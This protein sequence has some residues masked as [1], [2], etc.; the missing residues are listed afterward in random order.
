MYYYNLKTRLIP[1]L[2]PLRLK[3]SLPKNAQTVICL[4]VIALIPLLE[5]QN[6]EKFFEANPNC[7]A[8]TLSTHRR[9]CK[10]FVPLK[11]RTETFLKGK[12]WRTKFQKTRT[13]IIQCNETLLSAAKL[14]YQIRG[15][16]LRS[17]SNNFSVEKSPRHSI[18][19]LFLVRDRE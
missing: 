18:A 11:V 3:D 7:G 13:M 8:I 10:K 9:N 14:G 6:R 2:F 4:C 5:P 19:A 17:S 1:T 12:C 16:Y 15:T